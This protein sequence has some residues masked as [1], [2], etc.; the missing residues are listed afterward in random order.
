MSFFD[1]WIFMFV[2]IAA[3]VAASAA[4]VYTSLQFPQY[5]AFE[6]VKIRRDKYG[7]FSMTREYIISGILIAIAIAF[8]ALESKSW[9]VLLGGIVARTAIY[10]SNK[11]KLE[12]DREMQIQYLDMLAS[13]DPENFEGLTNFFPSVNMPR[14]FVDGRLWI[15]LYAK[16]ASGWIYEEAKGVDDYEALHRLTKRIWLIA[17]LPNEKRFA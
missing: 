10:F 6:G 15:P 14:K 7:Y 9:V 16:L 2:M 8:H 1:S 5:G 11:G 12:N 17:Q 3:Y 13:V 4:D